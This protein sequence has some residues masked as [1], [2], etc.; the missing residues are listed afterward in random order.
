MPVSMESQAPVQHVRPGM[1]RRVA[2]EGDLKTVVIDFTDGPWE[3]PEPPHSHPHVQTSYIAE[4]EIVFFCE[5]EPDRQLR[6]G[7]MYLVPS[8]KKHTIKVLSQRVRL[9]DNFY[10]LRQDFLQAK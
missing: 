3:E 10:P 1:T 5:G 2:Y 8:N 6:Q 7:D 9:I 4:G